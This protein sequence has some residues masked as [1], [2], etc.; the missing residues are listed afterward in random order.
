MA[1]YFMLMRT[2]KGVKRART[3]RSGMLYWQKST[4]YRQRLHKV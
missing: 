2:N 1:L 3:K 4:R